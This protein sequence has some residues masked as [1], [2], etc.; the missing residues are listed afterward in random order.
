MLNL[1][2]D[3][4]RIPSAAAE[5]KIY[6][7]LHI[8][9]PDSLSPEE[10]A[11]I[12]AK[13]MHDKE[14]NETLSRAIKFEFRHLLEIKYEIFTV[15]SR[16]II[17]RQG[18]IIV[19]TIFAV[20][21]VSDIRKIANRLKSHTLTIQDEFSE[22]IKF[23]LQRFWAGDVTCKITIAVPLNDWMALDFELALPVGILLLATLL[24]FSPLNLQSPLHNPSPAGKSHRLPIKVRCTECE[25]PHCASYRRYVRVDEEIGQPEHCD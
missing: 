23:N 7:E 21:V 22:I 8:K 20:R 16:D 5:I 18:S 13:Y 24:V 4:S 17:V 12:Y 14:F 9:L 19:D 25:R 11:L 2:D 10:K 6:I 1:Y 3:T 15:V